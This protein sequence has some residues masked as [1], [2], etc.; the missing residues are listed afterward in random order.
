MLSRLALAVLLPL[1][2][3]RGPSRAEEP[4]WATARL[5]EAVSSARVSGRLKQV[6]GEQ[7]LLSDRSALRLRL[8]ADDTQV[9]LEVE[10]V[11]LSPGQAD[12]TWRSALCLDGTGAVTSLSASM[13]GAL[14]GSVSA[15]WSRGGDVLR[16]EEPGP[17]GR[18]GELRWGRDD[19]P[20]S[21][22]WLWALLGSEEELVCRWLSLSVLGADPQG[23]YYLDRHL[24]CFGETRARNRTL[25]GGG[26][27]ATGFGQSVELDPAGRIVSVRRHRTGSGDLL[28]P[29]A[30]EPEEVLNAV[31]AERYREA[32]EAARP[33]PTRPR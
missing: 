5:R 7:H 18:V 20:G 15:R 4:S 24:S 19:L 28:Q 31:S 8:S 17:D 29:G 33:Q 21:A 9:H 3:V 27:L 30:E 14:N 13:A 23:A 25:P 12:L 2:V 1:I 26:R 22:K 10:A 6:A 32:L 16:W 11:D